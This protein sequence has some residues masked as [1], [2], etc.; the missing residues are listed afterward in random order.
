MAR[1]LNSFAATASARYPWDAD[2]HQRTAGGHR[3]VRV[4]VGGPPGEERRNELTGFLEESSALHGILAEIEALG[5][6]LLELRQIPTRP[7]SPE[8]G[9]DVSPEPW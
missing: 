4:P 8:C 1:R 5:L 9:D 2:P 6:E 7:K 3:S